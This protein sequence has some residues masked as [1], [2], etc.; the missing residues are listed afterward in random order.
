[1]YSSLE[2]YSN[3]R[4]LIPLVIKTTFTGLCQL[5]PH[6]VHMTDGLVRPKHVRVSVTHSL[7]RQ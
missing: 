7:L 2:L 4:V 1:M 6:T 5:L 3:S